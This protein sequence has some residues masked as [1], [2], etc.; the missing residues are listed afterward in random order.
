MKKIL[1]ALV[2]LSVLAIGSVAFAQC[3]GGAAKAVS[4]TAADGHLSEVRRS[5]RLGEVLRGRRG[6]LRGLRPA[7]G[8]ARL[9][10][11]VRGPGESRRIGFALGDGRTKWKKRGAANAP[12]FFCVRGYCSTAPMSAGPTRRW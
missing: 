12:R 10:G 9:H 3:G 7:Q 4:A 11:Q 6:S 1:V 8:L 2:A 5:R